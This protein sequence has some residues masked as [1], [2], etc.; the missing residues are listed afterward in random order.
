[1]YPFFQRRQR[2]RWRNDGL[3]SGFEHASRP[4]RIR[5]GVP[6]RRFFQQF[7]PSRLALL[8]KRRRCHDDD[9]FGY[10]IPTAL[11][12]QHRG[13]NSRR[14]SQRRPRVDD[15]S[16]VLVS[17]PP[18][19]LNHIAR[20]RVPSRLSLATRVTRFPVPTR[21]VSHHRAR[22]E[23]F[24]RPKIPQS[25]RLVVLEPTAQTVRPDDE[26]SPIARSRER[27]EIRRAHLQHRSVLARR[28]DG[29][30]GV[31]E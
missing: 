4:G 9:G 11:V 15:V 17:Q 5:L 3:S 31:G 28:D 26:R 12:R 21:A 18:R 23:I 20:A 13:P 1:M 14:P 27:P 7:L 8:V 2:R 16:A 10:I 6:R 25:L 22:S 30:H 29:A 19:H 24:R